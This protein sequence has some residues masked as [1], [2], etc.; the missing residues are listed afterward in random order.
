MDNNKI[1][2]LVKYVK[3]GTIH[4]LNEVAEE[5]RLAGYTA[6]EFVGNTVWD[7]ERTVRWYVGQGIHIAEAAEYPVV[8]SWINMLDQCVPP[9]K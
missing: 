3:T 9:C 5:F 7:A 2:E 8:N 4:E 6:N 1:R